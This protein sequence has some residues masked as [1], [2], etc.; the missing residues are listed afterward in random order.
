MGTRALP[1]SGSA[2]RARPARSRPLPAE[3]PT[4]AARRYWRGHAPAKG[5]SRAG[6]RHEGRGIAVAPHVNRSERGLRSMARNFALFNAL[7]TASHENLWVTD[8]TVLGTFELTG[9][10]GAP[11]TSLIPNDLTPFNGEFLFNGNDTSGHA[12]L[13]VSNG[14][15][16]GTFELTGINGVSTNGLR[17]QDLT[18]FN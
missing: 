12:G 6:V 17:P 11:T 13:W 3:S 16:T 14:T 4:A 1:T 18:V 15:S 7:N 5:R 2:S 8:G 10:N 9:I